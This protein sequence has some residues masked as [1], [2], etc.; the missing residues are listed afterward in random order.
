[1]ILAPALYLLACVI[2]AFLGKESRLGFWG[3]LLVGVLMT[4]ITSLICVLLFGRR[5][6]FR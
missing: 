5:G 6:S 2:A 1:M 4:P 3:V